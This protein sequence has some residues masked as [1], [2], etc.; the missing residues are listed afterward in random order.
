MR[1]LF[2]PP[3]LYFLHIPKTG[4]TSL[5]KLLGAAYAGRAIAV[6]EVPLLHRYA[7]SDLP[8]FRCYLS[9]CGPGILK[10][11]GRSD[12]ISATMLRNPVERTISALYFHQ[13]N[14]AQH[15]DWFEPEHFERQKQLA[16]VDLEGMLAASQVTDTVENAQTRLLGIEKDYRMFFADGA[17]GQSGKPARVPYHVPAIG[18]T[19]DRDLALQCACQQLDQM[20]VVGLTERFAESV[21]MLCD[22]LGIPYPDRLPTERIGVKKTRVDV[23]GYRAAISP[24]LLEQVESLTRYDQALYAHATELFEQQWARYQ[25]RPRHCTQRRTYSI[26]PRLRIPLRRVESGLKSWLRRSSPASMQRLRQLR[27]KLRRRRTRNGGQG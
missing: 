4:G 24:K 26:A 20:A 2:E 15:P 7:L 18:D 10:S 11:I 16:G 22:V 9:H 14:L 27:A 19:H 6:L 12:L 8:G 5:R 21:A 25:A 23:S 1:V 13:D 17:I 3:P